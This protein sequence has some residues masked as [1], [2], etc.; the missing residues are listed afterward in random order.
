MN[1]ILLFVT[2]FTCLSFFSSRA[3]ITVT[4]ASGGTNICSN[5]AQTGTTPTYTA[6]GTIVIN[7]GNNG[8]I[9]LGGHALV[10][11]APAGWQ[12]NTAATVTIT[13]LPGGN[14]VFAG[15]G[16][17]TTT[18]LTVNI[19]ASGTTLHDNITISGL[20]V[21]ATTTGSGGGNIRA[22][23][24]PGMSG[25][26]TGGPGTTNFGSLSLA[27]AVTPSVTISQ[28]PA[29]PVCAGTNV[30]FTAN[31]V[32]GGTPTYQW[33]LN[34][35]PVPGATNTT[36]S[37]STLASG[38]TVRVVMNATGCITTAIA[39]SP[40]TTMTVNPLPV[41]ITGILSVCPGNTTTLSDATAGGAWASATPSVATISGVGMV[42][43]LTSGTSTIS[44]TLPTGCR[45]TAEVTVNTI[46]A[47]FTVT[48]GGSLCAGGTG[49]AIGLNN[50]SSGV[51]YSLSDGTSTVATFAGTGSP[52]DFGLFT[53]AGT[54]TASATNATT[55]CMNNMTGSAVV[56]VTTPVI[57]SVTMALTAPLTPLCAG[58]MASF[59]ATPTNGGI[60]PDF[61][62]YVNGT[63]TGIG[64]AYSYAPANGDIVSV[65]LTP[66]GI[67]VFPLTASDNQTMSVGSVSTP[68]VSIVVNPG[69]P[70]CLGEVVTFAATPL[71]GGT[72]PTY[73][74]KKNGIN[75]ATGAGYSY[76]PVSGDVVFCEMTS[77]YLCRTADVATSSSIT[78]VTQASAPLPVVNIIAVPGTN[79]PDGTT[80]T[81][82]AVVTGGGAPVTYQ[83]LV[84]G[85]D[86]PGETTPTLISNTFVSGDIVTCKVTNM[87]PC[88]RFTL[89]SL[90]FSNGVSSVIPTAGAFDRMTIAPNPNNGVFTLRGSVPANESVSVRVNNIMGQTVYSKNITTPSGLMEE[91]INLNQLSAGLYIINISA[92][93]GNKQLHFVIAE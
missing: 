16:G 7:E 92:P 8:D 75:V 39:N 90:A 19:A 18:A 47:A 28:V 13:F 6:L 62:W 66:V 54:Y 79:V 31:P 11:T 36:Y 10:L 35:T 48:G 84:N 37:N 4:P 59:S 41:A 72:T 23:S 34:G 77:D 14:V 12:F 83:W 15:S 60:T 74:W 42:S 57:P 58:M 33:E 63:P 46:P 68:A 45:T 87:D 85:T 81:L 69:N 80:V 82:T 64:A 67:C 50:S 86:I 43:G 30:T 17:L 89:K 91:H 56:S 71:F 22:T 24:A 55:G 73:L 9:T 38:N 44:Y 32:N 20:E 76:I 3:A 26:V 65:T 70:S 78:M 93:S 49:V 88:A 25:I 27:A 40:T 5:F 21:I 2:W 1:K 61:Q 51:D 52:F 29:G 53:A